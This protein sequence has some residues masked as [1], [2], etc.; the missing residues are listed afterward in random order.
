VRLGKR[1]LSDR[2]TG[3][4]E[5]GDML[6]QPATPAARSQKEGLIMTPTLPPWYLA[7]TDES[8]DTVTLPVRE[9]EELVD[10]LRGLARLLEGPPTPAPPRD[11]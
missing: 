6:R 3:R 9:F 2:L 5:Q 11:A 4:A 1:F 10:D 7:D 8:R